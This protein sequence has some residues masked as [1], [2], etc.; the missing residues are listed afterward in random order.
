MFKKKKL[1]LLAIILTQLSSLNLARADNYFLFYVTGANIFRS[2]EK[3]LPIRMHLSNRV[4]VP[5][6][7]LKKS[8]IYP[9]IGLAIEKRNVRLE[10]EAYS[11]PSL[12]IV[13]LREDLFEVADRNTKKFGA[14]VNLM[15]RFYQY[16]TASFWGGIG[17]NASLK[18]DGTIKSVKTCLCYT[19]IKENNKFN[20]FAQLERKLNNRFTGFVRLGSY[21]D[22]N[23]KKN[24]NYPNILVYRN[25]RS[26]IYLKVGFLFR[27]F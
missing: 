8:L 16:N 3:K 19:V 24:I 22:M 6:G 10:I 25:N 2:Y 1:L 21:L 20:I 13:G 23:S 18:D 26:D 4:S 12:N 14:E 17:F 11:R 5:V 27:V 15:A 9:S 7:A